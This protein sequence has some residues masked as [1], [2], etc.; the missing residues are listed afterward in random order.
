MKQTPMPIRIDCEGLS[1]KR[2]SELADD[3]DMLFRDVTVQGEY[4]TVSKAFSKVHYEQ[5]LEILES[6]GVRITY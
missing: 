2:I 3:L 5:A 6:Y 4:I 1:G